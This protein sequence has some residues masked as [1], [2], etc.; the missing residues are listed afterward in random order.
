VEKYRNN[1]VMQDGISELHQPMLL[2]H[3]HVVPFPKPRESTEVPSEQGQFAAE[4]EQAAKG[5]S[6]RT[7]LVVRG[8]GHKSS[9]D[10]FMDLLDQAGFAAQYDFAYVPRHFTEG[11]SFGFAI[12]N[13]NDDMLASEA[14]SKIAAGA[15]SA[16]G[17]TLTAEWSEATHGFSALTDKYRDNRVMKEGMPESFRPVVLSQ[18]VPIPYP[19]IN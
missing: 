3:G 5:C 13:F 6:P 8:L 16:N 15:L 12:L 18:G 2:C 17:V 7:T 1:A 19:Q 4:A 14:V 9:V 11:S 10:Q